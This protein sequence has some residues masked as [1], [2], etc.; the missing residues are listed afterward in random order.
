VDARQKIN[1]IATPVA[2]MAGKALIPNNCEKS[3]DALAFYMSVL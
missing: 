1:S 3:I 2:N